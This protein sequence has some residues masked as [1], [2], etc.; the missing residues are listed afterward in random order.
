MVD[1]RIIT[2][3]HFDAAALFSW[4]LALAIAGR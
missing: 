4:K 1:G 3:E 2:A